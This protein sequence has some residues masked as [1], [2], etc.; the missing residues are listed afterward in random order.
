M[1]RPPS[2]YPAPLAT[3]TMEGWTLDRLTQPSRLYGANGLRTGSDGRIYVAQVAGSAVSAVDPDSGAIE[4]ISP[5]GGRITAPDDLVFDD[6]GVLYFTEITENRVTYLRPN[7]T[8]GVLRD[9]IRVANP[10]TFHNGRLITGEHHIGGRIL[11]LRRDGGEPRL[12]AENVPMPNAFEVG[13]DGMLYFPAQAA[14]EIWRVSL[15]GG[16]PEIVARDLGMPDSVKFH[17]DGYIVST[18]VRSGQVLKIELKS[19]AREVLADL[20]PG[21]DNVTFV[22]RRTFV[23]HI[24]GSVHE[25]VAPGRTRPLIDKGLQWPMGLAVTGQG[26]VLVADGGFTYEAKAKGYLELVGM[27]FTPGFPGFTRGVA[28]GLSGDWVVTT[29]NGELVRWS[30][31][32]GLHEVLA[33]G[34]DRLMGVALG[35]DG[36]AVFAESATGRILAVAGR[37]ITE[38]ARGLDVPSG[39]AIGS[40]GTVYVSEAA[41]GRVAKLRGG[42]PET[43][44][45]GLDRPEGIAAYG[46]KLY[47]L[48]VVAK[49]LI[50]YDHST[51]QVNVIARDLPVGPLPGLGRLALGGVG[52]MC[53]PMIPFAGLAVSRDGTIYVAADGE[54]S[55]LALRR[56]NMPIQ[57][58]PDHPLAVG[59]SS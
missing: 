27:L 52:D 34:F 7:G 43:V 5:S 40:D 11:E 4:T 33:T 13:P 46:D 17:P 18:Q 21:L 53:G 38:L 50:E 55:V 16:E 3:A 15:D 54:G 39:V 58:G 51:G 20:G 32:K 23:S 8:S 41:G 2:R 45:D 36:S 9:D 56:K 22:G 49:S 59:E 25:I 42:K 6:S 47:V 12:I 19:G 26:T 10:I 24:A 37:E 35:H 31:A 48:D 57:S 28:A 1:T 14:N 29:A 30:P 44:L